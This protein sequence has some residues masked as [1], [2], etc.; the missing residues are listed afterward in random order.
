VIY[1]KFPLVSSYNWC[2]NVGI[3]AALALRVS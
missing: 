2:R 3:S 1:F